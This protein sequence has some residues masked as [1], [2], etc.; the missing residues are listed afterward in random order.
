LRDLHIHCFVL[1]ESTETSE[2]STKASEKFAKASLVPRI[3]F[4]PIGL[5]L[6][7]GYP[8]GTVGI[9]DPRSI[10]LLDSR[11]LIHE[12]IYTL[13]YSPNGRQLAVGGWE[14]IYLWDLQSEKP[15]I[16][17]C[18]HKS[19]IT[20]TAYDPSGEWIA[21]CSWNPVVFLWK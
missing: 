2:E 17:L 9:Y 3:S 12:S 7:I 8:N 14:V 21:S 4:S 20:N 5:Q 10:D 19:D 11:M 1:E 6:A 16:R 15:E 13:T 18:G